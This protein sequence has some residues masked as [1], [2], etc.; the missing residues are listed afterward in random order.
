MAD[1]AKLEQ[2][3]LISS[4]EEQPK[5]VRDQA[6]AFIEKSLET[7]QTCETLVNLLNASPV[8]A[9]AAAP[10]MHRCTMLSRLA[11]RLRPY[12]R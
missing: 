5:P 4:D 11:G 10:T 1:P 7:A 9:K 3:I 6:E 8:R 2:A 12:S